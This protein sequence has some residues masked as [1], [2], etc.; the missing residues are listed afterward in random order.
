[1]MNIKKRNGYLLLMF[2]VFVLFLG[3]MEAQSKKTQ[4]V[5]IQEASFEGIRINGV[6]F[7][8]DP[9]KVFCFNVKDLVEFNGN[10]M[11]KIDNRYFSSCCVSFLPKKKDPSF[12]NLLGLKKHFHVQ[13][14]DNQTHVLLKGNADL[15]AKFYEYLGGLP[16]NDKELINEIDGQIKDYDFDLNIIVE[17]DSRGKYLVIDNL[18]SI[19]SWWAIAYVLDDYANLYRLD[20]I[21]ILPQNNNKFYNN[22]PQRAQSVFVFYNKEIDTIWDCLDKRGIKCCKKILK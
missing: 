20:K 21:K 3:K 11:I 10:A 7:H 13:Y 1:M 14:I 2:F 12:K 16:S 5:T 22:L 6:P 17:N 15:K 18:D 9:N 8:Y 19:N 4:T